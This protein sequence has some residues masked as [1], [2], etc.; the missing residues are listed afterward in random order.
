[1]KTKTF[2]FLGSIAISAL[3]ISWIHP[4]INE[5]EKA[6][7][8][9]IEESY[10]NGAYNACDTKTMAKGFHKDFAIFYA[11]GGDTLGK[12]AIGDWITGIEKRKSSATFDPK[13]HEWSGQF[14]FVDVT[15]NS[16]VAKVEMR[17]AN[18]LIYTDYLSL[19]KFESG[20]KIVGKVYDEHVE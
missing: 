1:M 18:K 3:L 17:K 13:K 9:V 16:A 14:I 15:G 5:E 2:L 19:I 11:E 20:W 8:T 7:K 10:F 4:A 6:V 12:Y